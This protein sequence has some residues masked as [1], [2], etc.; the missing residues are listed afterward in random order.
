[1]KLTWDQIKAVESI[2]KPTAII[3]GAGSG[4]T[5]V[6]TAR[7]V[8]ILKNTPT[9]LN[10]ILAITFTEKSAN[11]MKQ[12]IA[13]HLDPETK[14][15]LPWA[16]I[17]TFHSFCLNILKEHAP[18]IGLSH[19]TSVWDEHTS[20]LAIHKHCRQ[21]LLTALH[22]RQK[23]ALELVEELEFRNVLMLL[24]EL[25]AFRWHWEQRKSNIKD[26]RSK[27]EEELFE[28]TGKLYDQALKNYDEEKNFRQALDFQDLEIL[29]LKLFQ[30]NREILKN[31]QNRF[32]HIL[33]DEAQ[34]LNDLQQELIGLLFNPKKN[35]LCLV[36]DPK[37]SIYRFRGA[38]VDGFQK[39]VRAIGEAKGESLQLRENFRSRPG[40]LEWINPL[41]SHLFDP[42]EYSPLLATRE[43]TPEQNV[44]I[45]SVE[46]PPEASKEERRKREAAEIARHIQT[47]VSQNKRAFGDFA[48]LFQSLTEVR[49]YEAAFKEAGI[50]YR[51]FG[52][53]GFLSAQEVIDLLFCLKLM[54][55]LEDRMSLVGLM[56]SPLVG[57]PDTTITGL[58]LEHPNDLGKAFL[59]REEARWFKN[60]VSQKEN[61][62]GA[63]ILE[64]T[65]LQTH[66]DIL[67]RQLDPSGGKLANV[68]QLIQVIR[69][70]ETEEEMELKDLLEYFETLKNRQVPFAQAP[71][72]DTSQKESC[73]LMTVHAAK[74]LQ[75]PIVILPDLIR[76]QP[77]IGAHRHFF[78]TDAEL[79]K[80]QDLKER[81]RLLYVAMTRAQE[82][83]ILPIHLNNSKSGPWHSWVEEGSR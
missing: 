8:H 69:E 73:Q 26:Q 10:Q 50:P 80:L 75:F 2:D 55:N 71:A 36:G 6:L 5:E 47:E 52:G 37:Q 20:R 14:K 49:I 30:E 7:L 66:Y 11:E 18:L 19:L 61:L 35:I 32:E 64:Q 12:R 3:A 62:S 59:E 65:I 82:R 9:T 81:K 56:R 38:N 79:E 23:E 22:S 46:A 67:L 15:E 29:T 1:M 21:T 34:D 54:V 51:V 45:L 17:G 63:Q 48:L 25:M 41:F 72:V 24:E 28:A 83:L 31:V 16:M 76:A 33:I 70:L 60:L 43:P 13:S 68:E 42:S 44:L 40:I 74:G 78:V 58:A 57:F 77:N 4:K 53:R 27:K 39:M